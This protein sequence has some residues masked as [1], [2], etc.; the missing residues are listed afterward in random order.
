[1]ALCIT[2]NKD[3]SSAKIL[4]FDEMLFSQLIDKTKNRRGPVQE[5]TCPFKVTLCSLSFKKQDK[6]SLR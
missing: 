6:V 2:K 1:M 5:E 3:V 4:A